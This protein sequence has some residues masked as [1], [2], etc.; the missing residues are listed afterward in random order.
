[1]RTEEEIKTKLAEILGSI[2][3]MQ[4]DWETGH[5]IPPGEGHDRDMALFD[6]RNEPPPDTTHLYHK[7]FELAW[8]LGDPDLTKFKIPQLTLVMIDAYQ[9]RFPI[10]VEALAKAKIMKPIFEEVVE[11]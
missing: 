1:M 7:A 11:Q 9:D 6:P 3:D 5:K 8:V 2:H 4:E 10:L